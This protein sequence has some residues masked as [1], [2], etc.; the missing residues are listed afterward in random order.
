MQLFRFPS[1]HVGEHPMEPSTPAFT[2]LTRP[3]WFD[4]PTISYFQRA[5]SSTPISV[6]PAMAISK[7][8][9]IP[10]TIYS[11]LARQPPASKSQNLSAVCAASTPSSFPPYPDLHIRIYRSVNSPT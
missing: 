9:T 4:C 2:N 6:F 7:N 3:A 8:C 1:H 10:G 5:Q 11:T